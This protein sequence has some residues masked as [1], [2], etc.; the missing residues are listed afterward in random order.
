[1]SLKVFERMP[2][3]THPDKDGHYVVVP[4]KGSIKADMF[5]VDI[6]GY[7]LENGWN[8]ILDAENAIADEDMKYSWSCWLKPYTIGKRNWYETIETMLDEVRQELA[9]YSDR[10][11]TEKEDEEYDNLDE[12][13]EHLENARDFAEVLK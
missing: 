10:E 7:S 6:I 11:L 9:T 1:M 13:Y 2:F 3:T 12:L 8:G 4:N 5:P